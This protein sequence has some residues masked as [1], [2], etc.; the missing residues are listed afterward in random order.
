VQN[1]REHQ[2]PASLLGVAQSIL[3]RGIP[4][5][6]AWRTWH[7]PPADPGGARPGIRRDFPSYSLTRRPHRQLTELRRQRAAM[8]C[9][10]MAVPHRLPQRI[11]SPQRS[12]ARIR[13][14]WPCKTPS[15]RTPRKAPSTAN[16]ACGT[17][18]CLAVPPR[19]SEEWGP[20]AIH[21]AKPAP[22]AGHIRWN[23]RS[24]LGMGRWGSRTSDAP[25]RTSLAV[26]QTRVNRRGESANAQNG[27]KKHMLRL[28]AEDGNCP[29]KSD[30]WRPKS[31]FGARFGWGRA[32]STFGADRNR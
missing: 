22:K 27:G 31:R 13:R 20:P 24:C 30:V 11:G 1:W 21:G 28:V 10:Q 5:C 29:G 9:S 15:L 14:Y 25:V 17:H 32:I 19:G 6:M 26:K 3:D 2:R 18:N 16:F 23:H 8:A 4:F 7:G 12:S